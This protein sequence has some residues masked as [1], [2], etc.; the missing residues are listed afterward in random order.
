MG[1]LSMIF[2]NFIFDLTLALFTIT[3]AVMV[4][5]VASNLIFWLDAHYLQLD[6]VVNLSQK[7]IW[8]N[9]QQVLDYLTRPWISKL[10]MTNF[11]S[12]ASGLEHFREVKILFILALVVW[13]LCL[14]LLTWWWKKSQLQTLTV[15][16]NR[17]IMGLGLI[18]VVVAF[19]AAIDF[20][21]IFI[22]FHR[23]LFRN[24]DWLFDPN[25]DPIIK[26][27]PDTFFAHCFLFAFVVFELLVFSFWLYGHKKS[28]QAT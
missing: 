4:T 9:Y 8:H 13:I 21:D 27:L 15:I 12:S 10:K 5:I 18:F 25:T 17:F 2:L 23:L 1:C 20:D 22:A 28:K 6:L 16:N 11:Y 3:S 26:I 19:L 24:N 7:Q 14:I